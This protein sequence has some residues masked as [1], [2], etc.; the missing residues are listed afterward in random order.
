VW[1]L[2]KQVQTA[3]AMDLGQKELDMN[4]TFILKADKPGGYLY[5]VKKS[6]FIPSDR[7]AAVD[8]RM[9]VQLVIV[10]EPIAVQQPIHQ[11]TALAAK[12]PI[13]FPD[14]VFRASFAAMTA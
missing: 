2:L 1:Q 11:Q 8:P 4:L 9:R 5:I 10:A 12:D 6:K 13:F 14:R 3:A 7:H